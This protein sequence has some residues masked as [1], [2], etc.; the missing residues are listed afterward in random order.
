MRT[1]LRSRARVRGASPVR[2]V[3]LNRETPA[4][5]V[6]HRLGIHLPDRAA[7]T[8]TRCRGRGR[9]PS[10]GRRLTRLRVPASRPRRPRRRRGMT[11]PRLPTTRPGSRGHPRGARMRRRLT[12][13]GR[14]AEPDEQQPQPSR[15]GRTSLAPVVGSVGCRGCGGRRWCRCGATIGATRS[16]VARVVVRSTPPNAPGSIAARVGE[17]QQRGQ[18]SGTNAPAVCTYAFT[19]VSSAE[20]A[21]ATLA[22][23]APAASRSS[24]AFAVVV[25][26][27]PL[28]SDDGILPFD[29]VNRA[30][31]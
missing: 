9:K 13:Q 11:G 23:P 28:P 14:D 22:L 27:V 2:G 21:V 30:A 6:A 19:F 17:Q 3:G 29:A 24:T 20:T 25:Q 5:D 31:R 1:A 18:R 15:S 7:S 26:S 16:V 10:S 4:F 12:R 8:A